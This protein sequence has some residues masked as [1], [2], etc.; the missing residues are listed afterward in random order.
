MA[1]I[2]ERGVALGHAKTPSPLHDEASD[3]LDA[4]DSLKFGI[5]E[6]LG[7]N[8]EHDIFHELA[9]ARDAIDHVT[10]LLGTDAICY[11]TDD[12]ADDTDEA[13]PSLPSDPG[14]E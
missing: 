7:V 5:G 1:S 3:L 12:E 10:W 8:A 4:I 11:G 6:E 9:K 13:A 2:S 14:L